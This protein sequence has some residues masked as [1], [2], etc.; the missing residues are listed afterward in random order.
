MNTL[1]WELTH[2]CFPWFTAFGTP[3]WWSNLLS[4]RAAPGTTQQ[5]PEKQWKNQP[6]IDLPAQTDP[7]EFGS[8]PW[9]STKMK[10]LM[11]RVMLG[12]SKYNTPKNLQWQRTRPSTHLL[13]KWIH[14]ITVHKSSL[15]KEGDYFLWLGSQGVKHHS[16]LQS[17][18][19]KLGIRPTVQLVLVFD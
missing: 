18:Q 11:S 19:M 10:E 8:L 16:E 9:R 6:S 5:L 2:L 4:C 15:H 3:D 1:R 7:M 12:N 14:T 13:L 17:T